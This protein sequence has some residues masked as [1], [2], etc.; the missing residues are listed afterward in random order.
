MSDTAKP[1]APA[2][3]RRVLFVDDDKRFLDTVREL[4]S[5]LSDGRWEVLTAEGASRAFALLQEQTVDMA[6]IDVQMGVMD[7]IQMLSLLNR[8]YPNV[9]K[10]VLT[11]FANE[12]YRA[13]CLSNGAELYLEK[14]TDPNGW[15]SLYGVLSEL[16]KHRPEEGFRGV[17]RRVGLQDV[18]QMECLS[19]NSSVLEVSNNSL[20]GKIF[21]ETGQIVHAQVADL[22]GEDALNQLLAL[23]GGQFNLKMFTEPTAR[24]ITGQWEF[25][26]MEAAR[27]SDEGKMARDAEASTAETPEEDA[28]RILGSALPSELTSPKSIAFVPAYEPVPV[29]PPS[30]ASRPKVDEMLVCSEKGEVLYDW[31]CTNPN[32]WVSFFEFISQR[33]P[34]LS[35]TLPLGEFS[36]VEIESGGARVVVVITNQQGV[37]VKTRREAL[38]QVI[39]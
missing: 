29:L 22:I 28:A 25:L 26:L 24:T 7:G 17:L 19:R 18:L 23:S 1:S 10:V 16:V 6:V 27:K 35:Q 11:G 15:Q 8:G 4:M 38:N 13:A 20:T 33:G 21:I 31:Q 37:M 30:V 3:V 34:R 12:K 9:Q 2:G 5:V 14:P 32:M 39:R 36:R